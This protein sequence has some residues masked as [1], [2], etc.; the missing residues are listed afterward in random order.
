MS[1]GGYGIRGTEAREGAALV[2]MKQACFPCQG[3]ESDGE[4]AFEDL[5]DGFEEDDD[6]E[7]SRSVVGGFA[8]RV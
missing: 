4:D 5:G 7:G 1:E 6:T 2:W 3:G 8:S